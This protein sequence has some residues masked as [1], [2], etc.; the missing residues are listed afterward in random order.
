M[1]NKCANGISLNS[2]KI[3]GIDV[4]WYAEGKHVEGSLISVKTN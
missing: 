1:G 4:K 3:T 2:W